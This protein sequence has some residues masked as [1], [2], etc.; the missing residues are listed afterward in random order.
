MAKS[1]KTCMEQTEII[2]TFGTYHHAQ[3]RLEAIVI[4]KFGKSKR[5]LP[6]LSE[7][8]NTSSEHVFKNL[9]YPF[10]LTTRL[11]VIS[12]AKGEMG[13]HSILETFPKLTGEKTTTV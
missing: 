3:T 2:D 13:S 9:I 4:R 12:G 10:Y 1:H 7:R 5:I 8:D 6:F 11:W